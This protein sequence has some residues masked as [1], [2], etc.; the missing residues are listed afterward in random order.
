M[1][2]IQ[3]FIHGVYPRSNPLAQVTREVDRNRK[4]Q[5]DLKKQQLVDIAA[6][7]KVQKEANVAFVEDGKLQWQDIFRPLVEATKGFEVGPLTRWFDNNTFYRQPIIVGKLRLDAK[8]LDTFLGDLPKG[9]GKVTLPSP[10]FFAKVT[11]DRT[12]KSFEK[13]L[14]AITALYT[15]VVSYLVKKKIAV[16]QFNEPYIPYHNIKKAEIALLAK[17][18]ATLK[19]VKG[20]TLFAVQGYFGDTA[21]LVAG[22]SGNKAVDLLGVDFVYTQLA[23]LPKKFSHGLIAGIVEGRNSLLEDKKALVAFVEKVAKYFPKTDIY[24]SNNSDLDL[25]PETVA[26]EKVQLL[27]EIAKH[28]K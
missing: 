18:L 27:G 22:L 26:K 20:D 21:P 25:L 7:L 9:K 14:S 5:T 4:T 15:D 28:F 16:I 2:K 24:L 3:T 13:T 1:A 8:K 19:K 17:S 12:T 11:E 10:F 23:S 6:V